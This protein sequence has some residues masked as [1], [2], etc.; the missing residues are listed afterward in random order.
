MTK[1]G[2]ISEAEKF[3]IMHHMHMHPRAIGKKIGRSY[4]FVLEFLN[5]IPQSTRYRY[6]KKSEDQEKEKEEKTNTQTQVNPKQTMLSQQFAKRNG[7]VVMT[8]NAS[9][10]ADEKRSALKGSKKRPS[11]VTKIREED[12][13]Q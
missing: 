2:P 10:M 4:E 9:V 12:D 8:Q 5:S 13:G 6:K 1:K 7:T 11:C 3:Y